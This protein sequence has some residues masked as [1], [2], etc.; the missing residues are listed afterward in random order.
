MKTNEQVRTQSETKNA[1]SFVPTV[2]YDGQCPLC[3]REIAH[4]RRLQGAQHLRWIDITG[5]EDTLREYGLRPEVAMK[6]FHVL[7]SDGHWQTG[8]WGFAELWSHLPAYKWL[9]RT[10]RALHLLPMLDRIY[11]RFARRRYRHS[12]T[13]RSCPPSAGV[14]LND[15]HIKP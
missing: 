6:R 9:A 3:S 1:G 2:F 4:Y 14:T 11:T 13:T 15:E 10:L 8:A 7:D 12:C 5:E